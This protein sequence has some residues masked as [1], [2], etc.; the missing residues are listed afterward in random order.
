MVNYA[1]R[2]DTIWFFAR[3]VRSASEISIVYCKSA[4]GYISWCI[5][6][7]EVSVVMFEM[8]ERYVELGKRFH[9]IKV[10]CRASVI[11]FVLV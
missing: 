8:L 7:S 9:F 11:S 6:Y 1:Q 2:L 5:S 4:E 10:K 3:G